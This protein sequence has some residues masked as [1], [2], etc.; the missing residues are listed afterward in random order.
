MKKLIIIAA[1]ALSALALS[2]VA[3]HHVCEIYFEHDEL[4]ASGVNA[5]QG[6]V[7]FAVAYHSNGLS[8]GYEW[9]QAKRVYQDPYGAYSVEWDVPQ[10]VIDDADG[11][12]A[13]S[14]FEVNVLDLTA[15]KLF[16]DCRLY[17]DDP[18]YP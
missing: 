6:H 9:I 14:Y 2:P 7:L 18:C 11:N 4:Y 10:S 13:E 15:Q 1:I 5:P 16:A 12:W 8:G 17:P 3:N